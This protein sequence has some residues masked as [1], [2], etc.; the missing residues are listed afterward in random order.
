MGLTHIGNLIC[1]YEDMLNKAA[2]WGFEKTSWER[3]IEGLDIK[4]IDAE[5][6]IKN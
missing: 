3:S 6:I 5:G 1:K 2:P 4:I